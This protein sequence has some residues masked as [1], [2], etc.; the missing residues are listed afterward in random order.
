MKPRLLVPGLLPFDPARE[1]LRVRAGGSTTVVLQAGDRLTVRDVQGA[2]RALLDGDEFGRADLFG[3]GSPP[4]AE[5]VFAATR[6]G[7]VT[8]AAPAGEPV[9]EGGIPATDLLL[10]LHRA[11]PHAEL[12]PAL[13]EPLAEP[14][15]DFEVPRASARAYEVKAGEWIQV[16][17]VKGRQCSDFLA[18]HA[19]KLQEG[20]ERGLDSTTTRSLMG[21]AYPTPG[22]HGKFYDQ[23]QIALV[24][25]IRD[26][27]GRHDTFGL[28]C[29]AKYYED[30]GYFGHVNC[31]D[32][33]N[34]ELLPYTIEQRK[35]WPAINLFFNTAFDATN[36]YVS[37]E[38]WSRPGDYVLFKAHT[39]L[40]CLSS[41]C[42]D[43]IDPANAWNPT[44]V[45]VRVYPAKERFSAAI[46][47][48]VT[49]D[50]DPKLTR[51]TG[52]RPRTGDLTGRFTEY[53][54]YW[55]PTEYDN[56]GAVEEYWACRERVAMMDLS[57]L[58]KWEVLGP[59]AEELLQ[60]TMTR[61]IRRLA[62][63]H[64]VYTAVCNDTGGMLDDG[65]VFR[66]G[67]DNFRFVGG[68]EYDG[69]WLREEAERRSL[70]VWVKDST[71]ELANVAVQ[72]PGSRDLLAPL[73]WTAPSRTPFPELKWFRFTVGRV[74]G[75]Q[76]LPLVV[77][78]TGY[79]GELGYELFCHPKD[80]PALWDTVMGAGDVT[81]LGLAALDMLRI[82]AGLVFAGNEF[83]DQVDPFEAGIG[84]T[85]PESKDDDFVGKE[86]LAERRAHP[87]RMLV[88]LELAGNEPAGHGDCVHVGRH[89]VGVVTSGTRSPVLKKNIALCRM[90]VRHAEPGT[91]VEVGKLDG[92]QKRIPATVVR[93]PF[94]DPE[95]RRPRS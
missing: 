65:T 86:A 84:F 57:P 82:E 69:I 48:R 9:V 15:L 75:P 13:P 59:D 93:F 54:G 20:K 85:V 52:F 39:D 89:Q 63:G 62:D 4:G 1:T 22:L 44:E 74:G 2:Q 49:P 51:D 61:D 28:A 55:L 95:K 32:N 43:D 18:F 58:R 10:E 78:R 87:Q 35:G 60:S 77:S 19:G 71:D 40:V 12:E 90:N 25:V 81:P 70:R 14:R 36:L 50:A 6:A 37:D 53:N 17:D 31:T 42:P 91:E 83:D 73:V 92:F 7:A 21:N 47:H 67:P 5:E 33:F 23:D 76:G 88:G 34:G 30:L 16:I 64:V 56:L 79:T 29:Y 94:Y 27:V 68:S 72:G 66:L 80:A 24:E 3:A 45:H 38:P 41:A 8:V 46:A 11:T 26:T